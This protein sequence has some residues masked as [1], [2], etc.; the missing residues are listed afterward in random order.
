MEEHFQ[1]NKNTSIGTVE[2]RLSF[3]Y[4]PKDENT[5]KTIEKECEEFIWKLKKKHDENDRKT[6]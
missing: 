6:I 2:L 3:E 4:L 5:L 1:I